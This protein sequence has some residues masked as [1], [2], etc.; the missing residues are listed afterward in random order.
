MYPKHLNFV[1]LLIIC[2]LC[3]VTMHAQTVHNEPAT[4]EIQNNQE[5]V[6]N[7]MKQTVALWCLAKRL[8]LLEM[9]ST[10]NLAVQV[11]DQ[12][13]TFRADGSKR[14]RTEAKEQEYNISGTST[15]TCRARDRSGNVSQL[16]VTITYIGEG[17]INLTE[18][19]AGQTIMVTLKP[20]KS[21]VVT[22]DLSTGEGE[23]EV[24]LSLQKGA[25]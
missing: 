6:L 22:M 16:L 1:A 21:R 14:L 5:A 2:V 4:L 15:L 7:N 8:S 3:I 19:D 18:Q 10:M 17:S 12:T 23:S 20:V 25:R 9:R 24:T 11:G 13:V